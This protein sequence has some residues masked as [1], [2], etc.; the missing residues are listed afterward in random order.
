MHEVAMVVHPLTPLVEIVIQRIGIGEG[1]SEAGQ[2]LVV[3]FGRPVS[4]HVDGRRLT[5]SALPGP[6]RPPGNWLR[7]GSLRRRLDGI[8]HADRGSRASANSDEIAASDDGFPHRP[9]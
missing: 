3:R 7:R 2:D 4:V 8:Q 5:H 6:R 1:L 9:F